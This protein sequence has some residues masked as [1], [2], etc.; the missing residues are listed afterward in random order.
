[1]SLPFLAYRPRLMPTATF[2]GVLS[3]PADLTTYALGSVLVPRAGLVVVGATG[4]NVSTGRTINSI[5][6]G[7]TGGAL[8]ATQSATVNPTA[9]FGRRVGPGLQ[10]ISVAFDAGVSRCWA[11]CWL[12]ENL[13]SDTPFASSGGSSSTLSAPMSLSANIAADGVALYAVGAANTTSATPSPVGFSTTTT[14]SDTVLETAMRGAF[15]T[16]RVRGAAITPHTETVT[17]TGADRISAVVAT[18]R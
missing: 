7:G 6:I 2:L 3:D 12:L 1:M 9:L 4:R 16:K 13:N 8:M 11:G 5:S 18:F 15:A 10:A 17:P 14:D